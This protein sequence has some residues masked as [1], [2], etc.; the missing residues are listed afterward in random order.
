MTMQKR[1]WKWSLLVSFPVVFAL[2]WMVLAAGRGVG[3]DDTGL[4]AVPLIDSD[5]DRAVAAFW[6]TFGYA[7]I[8]F[9]IW[10]LVLLG[11]VRH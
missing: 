9:L 3:F 6:I 10:C 2:S 5:I 8:L 11:R 1:R 4:Y 7:L